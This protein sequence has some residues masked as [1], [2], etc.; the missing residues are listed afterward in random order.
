[1][2]TGQEDRYCENLEFVTEIVYTIGGLLMR[3]CLRCQTDM[4]ESCDIKVEGNGYGLTVANNTNRVFAG[5]I[6]KPKVA[7]SPNCG[8]ISIYVE[9]TADIK[10]K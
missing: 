3:K 2:T 9:N 6:G 5:R 4:V 7:I 1:M 8:E 10:R